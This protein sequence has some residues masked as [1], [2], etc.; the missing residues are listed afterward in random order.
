MDKEDVNTIN[1]NR[2]KAIETKYKGYRFRS[3]LEARWAIAFDNM[4]DGELLWE[5]EKEGYD[6]EEVGCYLPDFW[7]V[8]NIQDC[9]D[10]IMPYETWAEVKPG[11]FNEG[12]IS[13]IRA[14]I[15]LTGQSVLL[16]CGVP[17]EKGYPRVK[18][19]TD[20]GFDLIDWFYP[21]KRAVDAARSARF[22]HGER[23]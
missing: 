2:I 4:L 13:K 21:G 7:I 18:N 11:R 20:G 6:L 5:Y 17:D 8:D 16:L 22:E 12:E 10:Q 1:N 19:A 23:P 15:R 3:R 14:L 9:P